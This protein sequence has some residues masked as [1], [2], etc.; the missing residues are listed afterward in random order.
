MK[1]LGLILSSLPYLTLVKMM[2]ERMDEF[3]F[4]GS[5]SF[6]FRGPFF[7]RKERQKENKDGTCRER[8]H[9]SALL[10]DGLRYTGS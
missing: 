8:V 1:L 7:R 10:G 9:V 6:N 2:V 4:L 3:L 5:T